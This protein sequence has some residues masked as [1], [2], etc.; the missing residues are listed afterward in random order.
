MDKTIQKALGLQM[1]GFYTDALSIY[2]NALKKEPHNLML[3]EYYGG[4]LASVGRFK[5]ARKYLTKALAKTVEKPQVL[6]NLATVNRALGLL[7]EALLNI[8]SAIKF[9][10]NYLD[11]WI[12]CANVYTDL[13]QW[14]KA[15]PCYKTAMKLNENDIEPYKSL[16]HAFLHNGEYNEALNLYH[17]CQRKFPHVTNLDFIIGELICYRAMENFDKAVKFANDLK[18]NYDNELTWFEWVQT[19]W[20]A[21]KF[22]EMKVEAQLAVEKFGNY[23]AM[24]ELIRLLETQEME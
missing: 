21:K 19:L 12:N 3:C 7:D 5:E 13:R 4:A 22:K 2:S 8:K 11:A 10:P 16:A 14:D 6:N 23:P 15:I 9:K 17:F 18:N 24:I 20:L 1:N